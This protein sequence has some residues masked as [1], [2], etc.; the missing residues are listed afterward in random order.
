MTL[1]AAVFYIGD[2]QK[3]LLSSSKGVKNIRFQVVIVGDAEGCYG[4]GGER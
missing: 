2:K 1:A 3:S 4:G